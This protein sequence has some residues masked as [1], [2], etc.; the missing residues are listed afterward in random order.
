[1]LQRKGGDAAAVQAAVDRVDEAAAKVD[2]IELT[3]A[4]AAKAKSDA[5]RTPWSSCRSP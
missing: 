4:A 5:P 2:N 1:M 3:A